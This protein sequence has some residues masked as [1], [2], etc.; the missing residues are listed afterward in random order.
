MSKK[1]E[2]RQPDVVQQ[3][4]QNALVGAADNRGPLLMGLGILLLAVIGYLAWDYSREAALAEKNH[5][6]AQA[7]LRIEEAREATDQL[8]AQ[9]LSEAKAT[10]E[11][12]YPETSGSSLHVFV[13]LKLADLHSVERNYKAAIGVLNELLQT[14]DLAPDTASAAYYQLMKVY[15]A[16]YN[17]V[18]AMATGRRGLDAAEGPYSQLI[19]DELERLAKGSLNATLTEELK[20]R[21]L[22]GVQPPAAAVDPQAQ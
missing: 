2:L 16:D 6:L 8:R 7:T 9:K 18:E 1:D 14:K 10:L 20:S 15:I 19:K 21:E 22:G 3:K 4:L 13:L 11:A 17:V 5:R 12:L